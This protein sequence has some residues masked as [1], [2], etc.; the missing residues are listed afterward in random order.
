MVRVG[1]AKGRRVGRLK[2]TFNIYGGSSWR[3]FFLTLEPV[4]FSDGAKD[5]SNKRA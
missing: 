1:S 5:L 3:R 2:A 4:H